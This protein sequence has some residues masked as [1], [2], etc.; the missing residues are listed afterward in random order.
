MKHLHAMPFGAAPLDG[1]GVRFRLWAPG[2]PSVTLEW[3]PAG[4]WRE[5]AMQRVEGGWHECTLAEAAAG[6]RYRYRLP[7]GLRVPD[8]A[9]RRN[10]DDVHGP[11]EV[12]D[13]RAYAWHDDDWTGRPWRE[14]VIYELHIGAFTPEGSFAGAQRRLGELAALGITAIELMPLADFPGRHNWGYDGVLPFAPDASYGTPA[15]LKAFVDAAHGLGLMVLIDVV[16]NHFGPEGNY[17]HVYCPEFFNPARQTPWGAAIH[18]DGPASRTVRDFFV[19]NALYW[20]EEYRFDGLRM[21]AVHAIHDRSATPI[22]EEI[23][24]A[25]RQGPGRDREIHIVLE[26]DRN[27]SHRL[28]RELEGTPIAATAQWN[29][30]LHH[31]A[32]VLLTGETDGYYADYARRPLEQFGLALAQGFV[33]TGQPSPFRG[34]EARGEPCDYLPPAAFVSFLQTHDQVGNRAL[35]ERIDALA[36]PARLLA[37]RACVLLSPHTPMLFMGEE[38]AAKTPFRYFCDF[39]PELAAAVAAGRREEF[40]GFDA[41]AGAGAVGGLPDPN[42]E[43]TFLASRLDW[44]EH[45]TGWHAEA[46]RTIAALLVLRQIELVPRFGDATRVERWSCEGDTLRIVWQLDEGHGD[47]R[48]PGC[49]HLI[50]HFGSAPGRVAWPPGRIVHMMRARQAPGDAAQ[51]Q[52][53]PG[54]VCASIDEAPND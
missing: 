41:F 37:A 53:L 33:Y 7:D 17:L 35:G 39:G 18:F 43:A 44:S 12:V 28:E 50:A 49:L 48:A 45:S 16:Y 2:L 11:S 40:G 31:A 15:E 30:D 23:C 3:A 52:L 1:R 38:Y 22:V 24:T 51:I 13:P 19:H 5:R 54:G 34:G 32:H 8:P 21:D 6:D 26:N 25:L 36:D 20:I 9:S 46:L 27:E 47:A 4:A 10:P 29:D 14:A 42:D